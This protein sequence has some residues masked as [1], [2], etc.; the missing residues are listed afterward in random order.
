[1]AVYDI[2]MKNG[3]LMDPV[4]GLHD[5]GD[6]SIR[7]GKICEVGRTGDGEALQ[8]ID[9]SGCYVVPG[10]IDYHIHTF[11][12]GCEF[13]LLPEIAAVP[14]GVTTVVDGGSAGVSG[15]EGF[16]RNDISRS[17]VRVKAMLNICSAGQPGVYYLENME[18]SLFQRDKILE[19]CEKYRETIVAIKVRQSR[20]IVKTLGLEPLKAAVDIAAEAGLPVVVHA[21]DSP[22]EVK[23]TLD[24]LRKGDVFCHC[25][26]EKGKT[27]LGEDGHVLPEV[28]AAQKRGVLFDC[29]HGSMN[30]SMRIGRQAISEGFLPDI[31]SSDLSMLSLMKPP[32]YSLCHIMTEL[33]NMGMSFEEI[34]PRVTEIPAR[35]MGLN[36]KGFLVPGET[37]DIAVFRQEEKQIHL[38]DRYGN[39]MEGN[40]ML[41]PMMTIKDGIVLY[42][43]CDF[44]NVSI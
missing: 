41:R 20:E 39:S 44:F 25:F 10:L 42:R 30:F 28:F 12:S 2:V 1:M 18:P 32:A 6:I 9:A 14:N 8:T 3:M 7:K 29:A 13:A 21:T 22:G 34:L 43:Q 38:K 35:Q 36:P 4:T 11:T 19:L 15:F 5:V 31:I 16:Y 23:D 40:R 27:I 24:I 37:A 33:F 17:S 26:H